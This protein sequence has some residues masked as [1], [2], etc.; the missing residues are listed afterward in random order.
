M[1]WFP[2]LHFTRFLFWW[3]TLTAFR[4]LIV[5]LSLVIALKDPLD[6]KWNRVIV[7]NDRQGHCLQCLP[8]SICSKIYDWLTHALKPH[9][10]CVKLYPKI[11]LNSKIS[12]MDIN[13]LRSLGCWETNFILQYIWVNKPYNAFLHH[14][15]RFRVNRNEPWMTV[16]VFP[17]SLVRH[18]LHHLPADN[19]CCRLRWLKIFQ[20]I[21]PAMMFLSHLPIYNFSM[22]EVFVSWSLLMYRY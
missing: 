16:S 3:L 5:W 8:S 18:G 10:N 6:I 12:K 15:W 7:F 14:G 20:P 1:R 2:H 22:A 9:L 4:V 11:Y 21:W 17:S 19:P 13:G